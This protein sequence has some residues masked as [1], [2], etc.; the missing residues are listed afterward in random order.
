MEEFF[1][2]SLNKRNIVR[3]TIA[4]LLCTIVGL[5]ISFL[6][7]DTKN[8]GAALR[9]IQGKY[10]L[11]A[12]GCMV[13]DWLC[14]SARFFVFTRHM[15]PRVTFWHALRADL[16]AI[17]AGGITPFQTGGVGHIYIFNRV[18]VPISGAMTTGIITF[19]G[20]LSVLICSTGYVVWKAPNF[21][22]KGITFI[23]Q[24]S[25]VMFAIVLTFFVL[26]VVKPEVLLYFLS[27][28]PLP[29]QRRFRFVAKLL[30]RLMLTLEK[31][32]E[33][34][35]GFTR[36]FTGKHKIVWV[37]SFGLSAGVYMSRFIGGYVIVRALGGDA[38]FWN[39]VA[40]QVLANFVTLFAPTPGASGVAESLIT[41]LMKPLLPGGAT[42]LFALLTRFFTMYCGA[43]VGGIVLVSQLTKDLRAEGTN[44]TP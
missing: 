36:L 5:Y 37:W 34:H 43:A 39:V 3:G 42:W 29:R 44:R 17:C 21:L 1:S 4:F 20:S 10:L 12:I 9:A 24:Y 15:S 41:G 35:K 23:S 26:M 14:G 19:I 33:E 25:L 30:D 8:I 7:S 31:V 11:L 38:P 40:V 32:I 28:I 2:R 13:A 6:L 27:R 18:G 16:A 22:P